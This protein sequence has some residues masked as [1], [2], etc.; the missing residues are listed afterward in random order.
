M[1]PTEPV[2][3]VRDREVWAIWEEAFTAHV[4]TRAFQRRKAAAQ[5]QVVRAQG[6]LRRWT[7]CAMISGGKDSTALGELLYEMGAEVPLA[8]EKDDLDYPGERA[9]VEALARRWGMP[10]VVLEPA[11]SLLEQLRGLGLRADDD[12]HG[13]AAALSQD[14]FYKLVEAWSGQ[15]ELVYLGLRKEESQARL[16][17]RVTRGLL[18][19]RRSGQWVST[20]LGDWTGL[21]VLAYCHSRGVPLLPVYRCC[22]WPPELQQE[23]WRIRKSWWLPGKSASKGGAVW[24]RRYWPSLWRQFCDLF[25][26]ARSLA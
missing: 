21:D 12:L 24:L 16:M 17:N 8:S 3:T 4:H 26:D 23:P 20:P 22:A 19:Q 11:H 13:R 25:P 10:L 9:H 15:F 5:A 18:Y 14:G 7:A 6:E 1:T 2:L